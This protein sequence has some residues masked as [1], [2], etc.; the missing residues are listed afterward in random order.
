[1]PHAAA[2]ET[3]AAADKELRMKTTH[4]R[5]LSP[6]A[7]AAALSLPILT[8]G[9]GDDPLAG[10]CCT[11]FNV[12]ADLSNVD[13]GVDAD[14]QGKF[15]AFAQASADLAGTVAGALE[16][17][18]GACRA[19][20]TAGGA[21]SD[22]DDAQPA[23]PADRVNF[24]CTL[25]E[26]RLEAAFGANAS[27]ALTIQVTPPE[28]KASF[29]AEANCQASCT[30][31][32][33][34]DVKANPP[35]CEGGKL[36]VSCS[37]SCSAE[38][39]ASI[40][41]EGKCEGGCTGSCTA[42]GGVAVECDGQCDGTCTAAGGGGGGGG[43]GGG[44]QAD[45][46]CKGRC[47]GTCTA[48][49]GVELNCSGQCKGEC[50]ASCTA[51]AGATVKCDGQCDGSFEPL[52][53]KGGELKA[54]CEVDADCSGNCSASAEAKAECTPPKVNIA[55]AAGFSASAEAAVVVDALR[56]HLPNILLV[57]QAR[58]QA[59]VSLVAQVST[60][61]KA[62]AEGGAS[63]KLGLKGVACIGAI[64]PVIAQA[65][66]NAQ[67]TLN[68]SGKITGKLGLGG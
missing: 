55:F 61:G 11:D 7:F 36:E 62:I 45:G 24:W 35:T 37:G 21:N 46:S 47:D 6:L 18:S 14:F 52:S 41:C 34:C 53:C 65:T 5:L 28:C 48:R 19:I 25:A 38:A 40:S 2:V 27:A 32:A 49:A 8:N 4:H 9:C 60:S 66:T 67:A 39:G 26:A 44:I 68:A 15:G 16:D 13:W 23:E 57:V 10:A 64:V 58:G 1:M 42:E 51:E 12:G 17:V 50:N 56:L 59:F 3:I 20:A 63:G 43:A 29:K 31:D 22:K 33:S 54:G 30:V